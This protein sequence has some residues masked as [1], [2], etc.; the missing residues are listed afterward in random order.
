MSST[1]YDTLCDYQNDLHRN[2]PRVDKNKR[3]FSRLTNNRGKVERVTQ[4]LKRQGIATSAEVHPTN[5]SFA[6][7]EAV[8]YVFNTPRIPSSRFSNG[9]FPV[10]YGAVE[11]ETC[12]RE[13]SHHWQHGFIGAADFGLLEQSVKTFRRD[14]LVSC[15]AALI[16][17]RGKTKTFPDLIAKEQSSYSSTQTIGQR[18]FEEGHPGLLNQSAR[19]EVGTCAA[20]FKASVLSN[21]RP[22]KDFV[23]EIFPG[24]LKVEVR[25]MP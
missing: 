22:Y 4:C 6:W 5:G 18:V 13:T 7:H 16:D 14:Y 23:Y 3:P 11:M 8:E 19:H 24:L 1:L 17:L 9:C 10:W 12:I 15:Q 21:P 20:I 25:S 2:I